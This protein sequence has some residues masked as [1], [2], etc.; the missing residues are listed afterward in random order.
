MST[1]QVEARSHYTTSAMLV[2]ALAA[3]AGALALALSLANAS[4]PFITPTGFMLTGGALLLTSLWLYS[5][6]R[7]IERNVRPNRS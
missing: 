2:G 5:E 6:G 1:H 4:L 3:L 7:A